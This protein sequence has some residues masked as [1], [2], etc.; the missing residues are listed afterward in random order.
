MKV[1]E[2]LTQDERVAL[3]ERTSAE[4]IKARLIAFLKWP[5]NDGDHLFYEWGE[6]VEVL[7]DGEGETPPER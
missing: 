4:G 1:R 6:V 7:L 3:A 2:C 5:A